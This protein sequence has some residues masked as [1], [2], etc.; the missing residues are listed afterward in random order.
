MNSALEALKYTMVF[1]SGGQI[2]S[3]FPL[4]SAARGARSI[5]FCA[6]AT[7]CSNGTGEGF[8]PRDDVAPVAS[9]VS[10]QDQLDACG[11][12]PINE[13]VVLGYVPSWASWTTMDLDFDTLTHIALA[14]TNPTGPGGSTELRDKTDSEIR[15]LVARAHAGGVKVLAS[16]GG[17]A[18]SEAVKNAISSERVDSY[19]EELAQYLEKYDLDGV[20]V[21]IEGNS[22]DSTYAPLVKKL[23]AKIRPQG[24]IVSAAVAGWFQEGVVDDALFCFDFINLMAYDDVGAEPQD[25]SSLAFS[26][27]RLRYWSTDRSYPKERIVLGLPFYG[28]CWKGSCGNGGQ[29]PFK[30]IKESHPASGELDRIEE[31]DKIIWFNGTTTL[32]TKVEYSKEYGGIMIWDM[33]QDDEAATLFSAI[34]SAL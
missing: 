16:I 10:T 23:A 30:R 17:Y 33:S 32:K 22:V 26:R 4:A 18:E 28:Y 8:A 29:I 13:K 25:H 27:R 24:K 14:F 19:I 21:D 31:G 20:D 11:V 34:R 9:G 5:L 12:L 3:P 2:V 6:L 7:A 15:A 1:L